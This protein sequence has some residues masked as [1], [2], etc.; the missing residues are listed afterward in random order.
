MGRE[1]G[2]KGADVHAPGVPRF[3][4]SLSTRAPNAGPRK[5]LQAGIME[6]PR[7]ACLGGRVI[8]WMDGGVVGC[9]NTR[10]ACV[11][12]YKNKLGMQMFVHTY[13]Q[14]DRGMRTPS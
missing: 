5:T 9:M 8:G 3:H 7:A 12:A 4:S 14:T 13:D 1:G 2:Q 10:R 6:V 11:C